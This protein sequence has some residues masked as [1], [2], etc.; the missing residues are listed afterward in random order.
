M[1]DLFCGPNLPLGKAFLYCGWRCLPVDWALDP[2]HDLSNPQRQDSIREQLQDAVFAA[3]AL[4]CSTKSR[5]REIPRDLGDGKP[6]PR[7]LR[8]DRYPEGLPDLPRADQLRVSKDNLA[9]SFVLTELQALADRG[10][11]SVRENPLRSLHWELTQE[12]QMMAT[13]PWQ[14]TAAL[15]GRGVRLSACATTLMRLHSG[16]LSIATTP[17]QPTSGSLTFRMVSVCSPPRRRIHRL[18]GFWNCSLRFLVGRPN[19]AGEAPR[20]PFPLCGNR[21]QAGTLVAD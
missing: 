19:G 21:G 3:A 10:G 16:L 12:K 9:C 15:W 20:P 13:G 2:S 5:A 8:S 4:D 1:V 14:D 17:T 7:P 6:G 18:A 11:G